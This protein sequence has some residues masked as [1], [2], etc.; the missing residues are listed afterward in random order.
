MMMG[1]FEAPYA[2]R[3]AVMFRHI[4]IVITVTL[5]VWLSSL[6]RTVDVKS[7]DQRQAQTC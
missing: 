6:N 3:H 7:V 5:R 1:P 2:S 4:C